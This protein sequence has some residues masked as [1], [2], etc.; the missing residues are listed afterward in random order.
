MEKKDREDEENV[1]PRL[2]DGGDLS[3]NMNRFLM[4]IQHRRDTKQR[5]KWEAKR[6]EMEKPWWWSS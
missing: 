1:N 3:V 2:D 6:Q 5:R 4:N